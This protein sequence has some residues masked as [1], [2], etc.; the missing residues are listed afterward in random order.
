MPARVFWTG[1]TAY[2]RDSVVYGLRSGCCSCD[3]NLI[4]DEYSRLQT[5]TFSETYRPPVA[6]SACCTQ[7][8][9]NASISDAR[10]N[11]YGPQVWTE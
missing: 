6:T 9:D 3:I 5:D 2:H 10:R 8:P 1:R 11:A 4:P 7:A